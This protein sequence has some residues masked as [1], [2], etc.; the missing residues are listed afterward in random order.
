MKKIV[1]IIGIITIVAAIG[2]TIFVFVVPRSQQRQILQDLDLE[3]TPF[4][5]ELSKM[6]FVDLTVTESRRTLIGKKW[7]VTATLVNTNESINIYQVGIR[8]HFTN[9]SE[10]RYYDVD[11]RPGRILPSLVQERI[12]GHYNEELLQVELISAD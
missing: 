10:D 8:Y 11:L 6:A 2:I 1:Y 7:A 3:N 5:N 9:G 4:V 12:A